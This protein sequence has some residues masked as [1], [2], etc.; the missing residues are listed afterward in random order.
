MKNNKGITLIALV[1]TIVVLLILAGVS[2]SMLTGEN[3]II[4]QAQTAK[5]NTRAGTVRDEVSLWKSEN[6]I[7]VQKGEEKISKEDML[8]GL[9]NKELV[10]EEEIDRV[11]EIIRIGENEIPYSEE[12]NILIEVK[13]MPENEEPTQAVILQVTKVEGIGEVIDISIPEQSDELAEKLEK[14]IKERFTRE[15]KEEILIEGIEKMYSL[16][17]ETINTID[18]VVE[19]LIGEGFIE[20]K[21]D[22]YEN[23]EK[24]LNEVT[25]AYG[26]F[27]GK[28]GT[29]DL[30]NEVYYSYIIK[31]PKGE[32]SKE[33]IATENGE[34][35]FTVEDI[36][37][38]KTYTKTITVDNISN[39]MNYH[40]GIAYHV[41]LI[42]NDTQSPSIFEEA[43]IIHYGRLISIT[44]LI[45]QEYEY[46]Y[47]DE[48]AIK[49]KLNNIVSGEEKT[50]ILVKDGKLYIGDVKLEWF[51]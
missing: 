3:G 25:I 17:E 11:A 2:I 36:L 40:V 5:I 35:T 9:K 46:C 48:Y 1:V 29:I 20:K 12:E 41:N 14:I 6:K 16:P 38:G 32:L 8:Q 33:Y 18:D 23:E 47:I 21:E 49:L 44:N 4:K 31:N 15:Q 45:E 26:I 10:V 28:L 34:Y 51:S 13:R 37:T 39:E 42:E 50:I 43:Y 22:L 24:I 27:S 30:E 7:R 19:I